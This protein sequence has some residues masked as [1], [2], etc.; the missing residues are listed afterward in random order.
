MPRPHAILQSEFPYHVSA[1]C[2]NREWF[3]IPLQ[4]VWN[5]MSDQLYFVTHAYSAR[6]HA[7]V[8]MQ[9]HF[10]L[11]ISTP[12]ANLNQI[13]WN[14]MGETSRTLTRSS[15]RINQT[16]GAR[17]SRSVIDSPHY[18]HHAYKYV[19]ANPVRAGA[20]KTVES[21]RFSTLHGLLGKSPLTIPVV[22]D[23]ILFSD[24]TQTMRWL[25]RPASQ[26]NWKLVQ[27][28]IR[29]TK[30]RLARARITNKPTFLEVNP[31]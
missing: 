11:L 12:E 9:N 31:L 1:R 13:M 4:N 17:H 14:F 24:V 21:Y 29:K 3:H 16:Y 27:Q 25:N 23:S 2:I 26:E 15:N 19:Y 28:A 7:F 18:F 8:L 30:F 22:D 6:I 5:I 10:H 20:A